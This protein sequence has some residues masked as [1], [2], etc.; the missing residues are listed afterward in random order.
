MRLVV[1][2]VGCAACSVKDPLFC[3]LPD[4]P[5]LDPARPFCDE[6]AAYPASEGIRK[7]CIP[8]PFD[9]A[10]VDAKPRV[11]A[12]NQK[13]CSAGA[14]TECD[15]TGQIAASL[16]CG[17]LGCNAG[18]TACVDIDPS[19]KLAA[20][21]DMTPGAPTVVLTGAAT[22]DTDNATVT[23]GDGMAIAVPTAS[24]TQNGGLPS[25]TVFRFKALDVEDVTV[26]GTNAIA[27]VAD[28]DVIIRGHM[29][30]SSRH[31]GL[32]FYEPLGGPGAMTAA[33]PCQ[34]TQG[35]GK[36]G[37]GG[38]GRFYAGA[39][40]GDGGGS[41]GAMGGSTY[42]TPL[43]E[44]LVGGCGGGH[45]TGD[46][47][48]LAGVGGGAFQISS[49]TRITLQSTAV[50]DAGGGGGYASGSIAVGGAGGGAGG[51]ILLEAPQVD[52]SVSGAVMAARGGGGASSAG[53]NS[54]ATP[55]PGQDGDASAKI[56]AGGSCSGCASGGEGQ[57]LVWA[58]NGG[59]LSGPLPG[60]AGAVCGGGGG[61]AT[62]VVVLRTESGAPTIKATIYAW[63]TLSKIATR[64][65]TK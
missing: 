3:E 44:P 52:V 13:I 59:T 54:A 16:T 62:G 15:G 61:G 21:L 4:H 51:A 20:Q 5:C 23:N 11:C 64:D 26:T 10:V 56:A 27:I 32:P 50:I 40:G 12:P 28:G 8:S 18:S 49:R 19:N 43:N 39:K 60:S 46:T 65:R 63:L 14:Y 17:P 58:P 7:T 41:G 57:E 53:Q 6:S 22:I 35:T 2:L 55:M 33:D 42:L 38:G 1:V 48:A 36:G 30:V 25:I 31:A 37:S 9:A 34:G 45:G 47:L 24:V 29:D